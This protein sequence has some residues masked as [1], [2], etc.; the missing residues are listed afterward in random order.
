MP[1]AGSPRVRWLV[2]IVTVVLVIAADQLTKAW[3]R[4]YPE[5]DVIFQRGFF[6][7]VHFQNTGAAFGVF[8]QG[9]AVLMVVDFIAIALI[10][11]YMI[12][13]QDRLGFL[14]NKASWVA[15]SLIFAGTSGNLIDRLNHSVVG[16]T[17]FLY[18]T[19]W[20]AF[21]VADSSITI[22]VILLAYSLLFIKEKVESK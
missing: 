20:P 7:I 11:A 21:N 13:F 17:D 2:F 19:Y 3:I 10:L 18:L 5:G 9:S 4:S 15:L 6:Q 14:R 1:R 22:G 12:F 16:I 8:Q